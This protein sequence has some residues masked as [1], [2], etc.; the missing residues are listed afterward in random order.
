VATDQMSLKS[1]QVLTVR[2]CVE[3]LGEH[4]LGRLAFV[5]K[6]GVMPLILPVNYVIDEDSPVFRSDP[7]SKLTAAILGAP[8]AFEVDG[9][10]DERNHTGWS[11]VV[12][13]HARAV[14]D[15]DEIARLERSSLVPWAPGAKMHFV[16]IQ[17]G[18]IS[19]RRISS[20]HI[21]LSDLPGHWLG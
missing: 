17:P 2:E 14:T 18:V 4:S 3:L 13:G 5:G 1:M 8:V 6:V 9:D 20:T 12:H 19:G 21:D 7:G 11:V 15:P 10:F 16:R